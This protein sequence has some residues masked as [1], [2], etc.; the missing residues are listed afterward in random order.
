VVL[1]PAEEAPL[2]ALHVGPIFAEA[3]V[4]AG[5][6]NVVAGMGVEAGAALA[7]H[8]GINHLAFTGSVETG[9]E[10]MRRAAGNVVPVT[11]ELGGKSPN[12]VFADAD[13]AAALE[14]AIK[15][16]FTN[17]GQVCLAGTRLLLEKSI[18]DD[19]TAALVDRTRR[20][21]VGPGIDDPDM[22]PVIS[23]AQRQRVMNYIELGRKEGGEILA[24]GGTPA[25][26][27][28]KR[29]YFIEPTLLHGVSNTARVAQEEIFGP[30]LT[31]IPFASDEEA[32]RL[33]NESPYGLVAGIWTNNL[34]RAHTLAAQLQAGQVFVNDYFS[35]SVASPFGGYK[36]SGFGRE[37]GVEA[38]DQYTQIKSICIK[39]K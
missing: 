1:K 12:I 4:P 34:Q 39:L 24:G 38:M 15:A 37:R 6:F 19:F 30:V 25:A 11:L 2:T 36:R 8:P 21:V 20:I 26:A 3:G 35:G 14:G 31:I 10:V 32:A 9:I 17:A 28:C 16:I 7:G 13:H 27:Q 29:G 33:A 5:V 23:D 18:Y 22:G